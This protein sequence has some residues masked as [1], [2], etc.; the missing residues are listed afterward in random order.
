MVRRNP[1]ICLV[2]ACAVLAAASM[3]TSCGQ[4]RPASVVPRAPA[5]GANL[6]LVTVDTLRA[7]HLPAYGYARVR[8]T[9]DLQTSERGRPLRCCLHSGTVDLAV[10]LVVVHGV[11]ACQSRRPRQ[12][13]LPSRRQSHHARRNAQ[14]RGVHDCRIRVGIRPGFAVGTRSRFRSVSR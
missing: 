8:D 13:R 2:A 14:E 4:D 10:A 12:R 5:S 1:R 3:A 7:D 9:G 6:L 11:A